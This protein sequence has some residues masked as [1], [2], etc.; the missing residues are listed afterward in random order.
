MFKTKVLTF[1]ILLISGFLFSQEI[2]YIQDWNKGLDQWYT[3]DPLWQAG[4]PTTGPSSASNGSNCLATELNDYCPG[5][6]AGRIESPYI[7]IPGIKTV[8]YLS[9]H[10]WYSIGQYNTGKFQIKT[11][12]SEWTDL[13]TIQGTADYW[14]TLEFNL[15]SFADSIIKVAFYIETPDSSELI[16]GWYIDYLVIEEK[17]NTTSSSYLYSNSITVDGII[18][19]VWNRKEYT[20]LENISLGSVSSADDL[21]AGFKSFW[22]NENLYL[23]VSVKDDN[24][25]RNNGN[26]FWLDD[27]VEIYFDLGY[28]KSR[29]YDDNNIQLRINFD[30]DSVTTGVYYDSVNDT[31]HHWDNIQQIEFTQIITDSGY[32]FEIQI[33]Y[34]AFDLTSWPEKAVGFD[35]AVADNDSSERETWISW[36]DW[37]G[38]SYYNSSHMGNLV[39]S[40]LQEEIADNLKCRYNGTNVELYWDDNSSGEKGY[41]ILRSTVSG[42]YEV[43]YRLNPDVTRITDNTGILTD[44]VYYY[45]IETCFPFDSII[46]NTVSSV[47]TSLVNSDL[48][49]YYPFNGNSNDESGYGNNGTN[50]GAFLTRDYYN[51]YNKA[52]YFNGYSSIE[53]PDNPQV[54]ADSIFTLGVWFKYEGKEHDW[55]RIVCKAWESVTDPY[56]TY[57]F[58]LDPS[59]INEQVATFSAHE[60]ADT[61]TWI[62]NTEPVLKLNSWY[63]IYGRF[64]GTRGIMDLFFNGK[65]TAET[66]FDKRKTANSSG[67]F[68][69]GNDITGQ[70]AVGT[71]DEVRFYNRFL[72]DEEIMILSN[73]GMKANFYPI[74]NITTS[75]NN[76]HIFSDISTT[77]DEILTWQWDFNNDGNIDSYDQNPVFTYDEPGTYSVKLIV[78]NDYISDTIVRENIVTINEHKITGPETLCSSTEKIKYYVNA[79]PGF[80]NYEWFTKPPVPESG[81]IEFVDDTCNFSPFYPGLVKIY[82]KVNNS[83]DTITSDTLI[84]NILEIPGKPSVLSGP[85]NVCENDI[86]T[87]VVDPVSANETYVWNFNNAE[88]ISTDT[89]NNEISVKWILSDTISD[90]FINYAVE[91][92]CG[93]SPWADTNGLIADVTPAAEFNA[94]PNGDE[95]FCSEPK[96][97]YFSIAS[98]P[99]ASSYNWYLIPSEAGIISG[100][101]TSSV[102]QWNSDYYGKASVYVVANSDCPTQS[103]DTLEINYSRYVEIEE[104][105]GYE[106]NTCVDPAEAFQLTIHGQYT[107]TYTISDN[108]NY[109][110]Y[111]IEDSIVNINWNESKLQN[112]SYVSFTVNGENECGKNDYYVYFDALLTPEILNFTGDTIICISETEEYAITPNTSD[113][114]LL[115]SLDDLTAGTIYSYTNSANIYWN[116]FDGEVVLKATLSNFCGTVKDSL[117]IKKDSLP[118]DVNIS[119]PNHPC[120]GEVS[121]YEVTSVPGHY[122]YWYASDGDIVSGQKTNRVEVQ[123]YGDVYS[124]TVTVYISPD[125]D[126]ETESAS[127]YTTFS[128]EN[129]Q[130]NENVAPEKKEIVFKGDNIIIYRDMGLSYQWYKNDI[131]LEGATKQ[132]YVDNDFNLEDVYEVKVC[133]TSGCCILSGKYYGSALEPINTYNIN[134]GPNPSSGFINVSFNEKPEDIVYI[135]ILDYNGIA[136][137]EK[138]IDKV[139]ENNNIELNIENITPGIY[140]V[141]IRTDKNEIYTEK[142]AVY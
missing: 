20:F 84:I 38:T 94:R 40:P 9:Y 5:G 68:F 117:T 58:Q 64:D 17:A 7:K 123:W 91:N 108:Y 29:L 18:D 67:N 21:S 90:A 13:L 127:C 36:N 126:V 48:T 31:W 47:S 69:I 63:K 75:K 51:E 88:L 54:D 66:L 33:P 129:I 77:Y 101:T 106:D 120:I 43:L 81:E 99:G 41:N 109:F 122:Y 70:G 34:T 105:T 107:D 22:N 95:L 93:I 11:P 131:E 4:I 62:Y 1:L 78:S 134:I 71:I 23:L 27:C 55:A 97:S 74:Y 85:T 79:T 42:N 140:L 113:A 19:P 130:S 45:K 72:T 49:A 46:N 6:A 76:N 121:V 132:F 135:D 142:I 98:Y 86:L 119:G 83:V 100:S 92:I 24:P 133:N 53:I 8:P 56:L 137:I 65:K 96:Y 44:E 102:L 114:D 2:T 52:Y 111:S 60:S 57:G 82:V 89:I 115:F 128:V 12:Y 16:P 124:G 32:T 87:Y 26:N 138:R 39:F 50:N 61:Q 3:N 141:K 37:D 116:D 136:V 110:T 10:Q 73:I 125:K 112:N 103:S 80:D 15:S 14:D 28:E 139:P 35:I 59:N 30:V 25:L 104:V 118:D